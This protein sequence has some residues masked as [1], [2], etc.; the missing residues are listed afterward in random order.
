MNPAQEFLSLCSH[1][2]WCQQADGNIYSS[3]G[4][5]DCGLEAIKAVRENI[6]SKQSL[7]ELI[8]QAAK[9]L[10]ENWEINIEVQQGYAEVIITNPDGTL[11]H[12]FQDDATLTQQFQDALRY[13]H[14]Q[15]KD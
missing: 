1:R 14:N 6:L 12:M 3:G 2:P 10:P 8:N 9:E 11:I 4:P 7:D 13:V 15:T 5:C